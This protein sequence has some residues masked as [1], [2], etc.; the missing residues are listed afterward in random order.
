ME[1][2]VTNKY[3]TGMIVHHVDKYE[4]KNISHPIYGYYLLKNDEY[5]Q[6]LLSTFEINEY[7]ER[8]GISHNPIEIDTFYEEAILNA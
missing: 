7:M 2:F 3:V 1:F 6:V 5:E 4:Y 8:S